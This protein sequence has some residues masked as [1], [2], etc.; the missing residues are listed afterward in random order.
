MR[1]P[2][3]GAAPRGGPVGGERLLDRGEMRRVET[4][5]DQVP[6]GTRHGAEAVAQMAEAAGQRGFGAR[7]AANEQ[8]EQLVG[9]ASPV[10]ETLED[11]V[12]QVV[13][14]QAAEADE[15]AAEVSGD[16][17][18][19]VASQAQRGHDDE[20][21]RGELGEVGVGGEQLP[22]S[23]EELG[24]DRDRPVRRPDPASRPSGG[25]ARG[26][27]RRCFRS[28][29]RSSARIEIDR[30]D[31]GRLGCRRLFGRGTRRV[32]PEAPL[33]GVVARFASAHQRS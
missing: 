25:R 7:V 13:V 29:C 32:V 3:L 9:Q 27:L 33:A 22:Q 6:G 12:C 21:R 5:V 1:A 18:E 10:I 15:R 26:R 31:G 16:R 11:I 14:G 30:L 2:E 17:T 23:S 8:G 20:H 28:G 19:Q 4:G 24:F